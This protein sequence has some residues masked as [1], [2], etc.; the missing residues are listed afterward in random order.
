MILDVTSIID[1]AASYERIG[2][3]GAV[4]K[5]HDKDP[6]GHPVRWYECE[7][8]TWLRQTMLPGG[9]SIISHETDC[10]CGRKQA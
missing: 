5:M 2:E 6:K 1:A 4:F 3:L 8:G 9:M 10:S 7:D